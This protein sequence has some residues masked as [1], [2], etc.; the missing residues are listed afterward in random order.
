MPEVASERASDA[1]STVWVL[2]TSFTALAG[3]RDAQPGIAIAG[4]KHARLEATGG[5]YQ[6]AGAVRRPA[7]GP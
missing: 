3:I 7:P 5:L 2:S 1:L 4:R 6:R